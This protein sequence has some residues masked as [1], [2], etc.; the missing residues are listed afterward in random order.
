MMLRKHT[1]NNITNA[2]LVKIK[3]IKNNF[4]F[5]FTLSTEGQGQSSKCYK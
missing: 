4:L 3:N 1:R 5:L 2:L